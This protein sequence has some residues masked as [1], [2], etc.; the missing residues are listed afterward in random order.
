MLAQTSWCSD[1]GDEIPGKH[2]HSV[3]EL[4]ESG[5]QGGR[6]WAGWGRPKEKAAASGWQGKQDKASCSQEMSIRACLETCS[7]QT[8]PKVN[9][10]TPLSNPVSISDELLTA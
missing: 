2:L 9:L 7:G 3:P 10:T 5:Q 4:P 8:H 6:R 1:V